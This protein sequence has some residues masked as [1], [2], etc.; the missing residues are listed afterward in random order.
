MTGFLLD[1]ELNIAINIAE[2]ALKIT[3]WFKNHT[4]VSFKKK[5]ESLVTIADFASQIYIISE[6][7][8]RFPDDKFIAE[9]E[10]AFL[11][12]NAKI[13]IIKCFK[14]LNIDIDED[15]DDLLNYRGTSSRRSWAIDPIDG[16]IGFQKNLCY[17]VGIGLLFDSEPILAVISVPNYQDRGMALFSAVKGKG[18]KA[19]YAKNPFKPIHVGKTQN[20]EDA[21][22][23][24][25]LHHDEPWVIELSERIGIKKL[26]QIDSMA[27]SCLVADGS[28]D[29]YLKPIDHS[30][31][32]T[33][34][35]CQGDLLVKE[36]GGVVTDTNNKNLKYQDKN[37]LFTGLG[38]VAANPSLH[39]KTIEMIKDI[40]K[41]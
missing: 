41:N 30:R 35:F 38:M 33:W 17:A 32:F 22:L 19:S 39:E 16:T 18:A 4:Y 2:K 7:K 31:S 29:I 36:A 24:H 8:R 25:S 20:F 1:Q 3:E 11:D 12:D 5:D 13:S 28:A 6:L 34:D 26:I 10:N 15:L 27:K 21:T 14:D 40:Y 37:C 9:E 23:S